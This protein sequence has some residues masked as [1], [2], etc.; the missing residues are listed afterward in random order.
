MHTATLLGRGFSVVTTLSRTVG[1]AWDLAHRYGFAAAC[2]GVHA[3]DIPVLGPEDPAA[4]TAVTELCAAAVERD[5]SD[6]V[7]LGCAGMADFC[8]EVARDGRAGDRRGD[9]GHPT[10]RVDGGARAED[11]RA[12]R[13]RPAAPEGVHGFAARLHHLTDPY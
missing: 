13:V 5:G 1:R 10:G 6:A 12:R 8:A 4:R 2:R 11:E 7:V 3:C 9:G